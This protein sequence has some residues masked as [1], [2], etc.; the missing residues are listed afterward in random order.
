VIHELEPRGYHTVRPLFCAWRPYL[1]TAA[2]IEGRIPGKI[3]ADHPRRPR[4]ALLWDHAEGELY[5]AG[6]AGGEALN[7]A[8]ND[9]I[10]R[11]IRPYAQAHLP[12]LSEFTLYCDPRA[13]QGRLDVVLSGTNPM[14]HHRRLYTLRQ[15]AVDW[16]SRLPDGYE[17]APVDAALLARRD[18]EGMDTMRDWVLGSWRSAADLERDEVGFCLVHGG[19]LAS[20]CV[21]EY[22]TRPADGDGRACQLGIYTR[23]AYRRRGF[24]TLVAAAAVERC[25]ANGI[26]RIGWHCWDANV[27]SAATAEKVGFVLAERLPVYN[28]CFNL[29]DNFLLQAHY[30]SQAQREEQ[31]LQRWERAF[32]MWEAGNP[33]ALGSPHCKAHPETLGWCYYAAARARAGRDETDAA[34]EHLH[35]A[36]G[37]GWAG[38]ERLREDEVW[39][40]LRGSPGWNALLA[41]LEECAGGQ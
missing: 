16:R 17:M 34:L 11:C 10:R 19:A 5:L 8:L 3:Y 26:E 40:P 32:A 13:C 21:S 41:R 20:W 36:V 4:S 39:A 15:L 33:E 38:V 24:A 29:F 23:E 31:A 12:D 14:Q 37:S 28:A 9:C 35:K 18:L 22:T 6:C 25:L 30:H 1:V 7:R 2:V 27:G